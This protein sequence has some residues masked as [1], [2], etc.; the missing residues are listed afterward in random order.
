MAIGAI[1]WA[2]VVFATFVNTELIGLAQTIT[3][4][5][6]AI[7]AALGTQEYFDRKRRNGNGNGGNQR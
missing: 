1:T 7:I 4:V 5:M 3:P 2:S 6:L